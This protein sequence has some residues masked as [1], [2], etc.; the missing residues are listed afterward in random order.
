M[1][2]HSSTGVNNYNFVKYVNNYMR[3]VYS[4]EYISQ[5]L[6]FI[7]ELR[8][9]PLDKYILE[10][11]KE[12]KLSRYQIACHLSKM[13][14]GLEQDVEN[15]YLTQDFNY[16]CNELKVIK[17]SKITNIEDYYKSLNSNNIDPDEVNILSI[18]KIKFIMNYFIYIYKMKDNN[19]FLNQLV[20][21]KLHKGMPDST[22]NI[23]RDKVNNVSLSNTLMD[24]KSNPDV[25]MMVFA[26][27]YMG[28]KVLTNGCCQ[29]EVKYLTNPEL[30]I[31]KLIFKRS[32]EDDE[33]I[34][35]LNS[36]KYSNY[37]GYG[38]DLIFKPN[39]INDKVDIVENS[40]YQG[41][42]LN[43]ENILEVDALQFSKSTKDKHLHINDQYKKCNIDRE[44]N[45]L[46]IGFNAINSDTIVTGNWGGGAFNG[47]PVLKFLI[48][49]YSSIL[50]NKKL[51]YCTNNPFLYSSIENI[52]SDSNIINLDSIINKIY[53]FK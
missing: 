16:I 30:I 20:T 17:N 33:T 24:D 12:I 15:E 27:K 6:K 44:I 22:N 42:L 10:V 18:E 7:Y 23:S 29:E 35:I 53:N 51:I 21:Y 39:D 2:S 47:D 34:T 8:Q 43:I 13:F 38:Y 28:G 37:S 4:N 14:N 5:I 41:S 19:D 25:F 49:W 32:L 46:L 31:L 3:R 9:I 1:N 40:T 48:Q 45:K 52:I 50:S 11:N 26:N 36:I